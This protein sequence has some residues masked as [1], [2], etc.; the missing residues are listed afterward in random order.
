MFCVECGREGP[1]VEGLCASC[2]A[3]KRPVLE[4]PAAIDVP[5]CQ[6]CGSFRLAG[7]W[8]RVDLDLA[9]PE[10]LR[11]QVRVLPPYRRV[12]FTH[13]AR[14]ED[15]NNFFLTVK[16]LGRYEVLEV[17]QDFH[18]RLRL[19]PTVCDTCQ[20]KEGRYYEGI[21]QVRGSARDL[22]PKEDREARTFVGAR[23][24]RAHGEGDFVSRIEEVRGGLDFYVST[25]AFGLRLA[26]ELASMTGGTVT[27]SPKLFG[28]REGREVYRVTAL[29][30][31]PPFGIGDVVRHKARLVEVLELVPLVAFRDLESGEVRRFKPKDL[32]G[33][34]RL[35]ADRFD[36]ALERGPDGRTV[37]SHPASGAQRSI[38][39]RGV[40]EGGR[41]SVIWTQGEAFTSALAADGSKP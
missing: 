15:P 41:A 39:T 6:R 20:K 32:R 18:T 19:K 13:V 21:L 3:K 16:A 36:A 11:D 7:G 25:N 30:R 22:T 27:T 14:E 12:T 8:T 35:E 9:I 40:R 31:L 5:R 37:V 10:A 4:P 2:F 38:A 33:A 26:K 34:T 17:V 24:D 28:Q 1:V 29:V 23:A